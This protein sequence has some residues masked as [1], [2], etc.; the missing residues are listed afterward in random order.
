M[1]IGACLKDVYD[2][3]PATD[4]LNARKL[5]KIARGFAEFSSQADTEGH[6]DRAEAENVWK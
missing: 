4:I 1:K 6:K 5:N 2:D 3:K